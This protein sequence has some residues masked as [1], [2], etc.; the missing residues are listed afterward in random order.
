MKM[1]V[2][3][4]S[5][6]LV[7]ILCVPTVGYAEIN[8]SNYSLDELITLKSQITSEITARTAEKNSVVVPMGEY[9]IGIDIPAGI[10]TLTINSTSSMITIYSSEKKIVGSYALIKS[11]SNTVGRIELQD[12]QRIE[13]DYGPIIFSPYKGLSF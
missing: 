13:I 6:M 7:V 2:R 5:L 3:L 10:Y 4:F 1:L 11:N 12:G 8:L 9:I